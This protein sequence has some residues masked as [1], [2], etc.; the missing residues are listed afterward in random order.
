MRPPDVYR[1]FSR[2]YDRYVGDFAEDLPLYLRY[3]R[4]ARTPLLE[5]GAGS[6]RLT[7]PLARA[8]H[9]VVA[10]DISRSM[11]ALLRARLRHEP[12]AV[13]RRVRIVHADATRLSLKARFDLVIVPYYT[14]NYFL[15]ARRR[16]AALHRCAA[17]LTERGR[18]L[19]DVFIPLARI[20]H[21]PSEPVAKLDVRLPHGGRIRGWNVYTMNVRRQIETRRHVMVHEAAGRPVRTERFTIRRRWWHAG[22]LQAL[23]RRH[24]LRVEKVLAGYRGRRARGDAEQLAWV[25]KRSGRASASAPSGSARRSAS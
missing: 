17:H 1:D 15:G 6:G 12:A 21:C 7:I 13:R 8:G 20:A 11:L 10:V 22:Q 3:A 9:D 4:R 19:I 14:F 25:L 2:F 24:R 5:I 18:L 16:D 23:F